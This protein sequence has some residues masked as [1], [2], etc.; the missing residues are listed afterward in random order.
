LAL[1]LYNTK[2]THICIYLLFNN[3]SVDSSPP[4]I[5]YSC[6]WNS[7]H[8]PSAAVVIVIAVSATVVFAKP[9]T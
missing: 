8:C 2:H 3:A 9:S 5:A 6:S 1:S 4:T 7:L